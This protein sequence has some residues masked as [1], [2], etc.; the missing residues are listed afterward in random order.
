MAPAMS[1]L[2]IDDDFAL[3]RAL[4]RLL[5][6]HRVR[7]AEGGAAALEALASTDPDAILCDVMMP[8]MG[9]GEVFAR[10]PSHLQARVI[11]MTGGILD[12]ARQQF[13]QATG[14]P[15]LSKPFDLLTL[16]RALYAVHTRPRETGDR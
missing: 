4:A 6:R 12:P 8:D 16:E 5:R 1:I 2:L 7:T 15:L 14:R 3:R 13:I 11:F 9:G 10:L